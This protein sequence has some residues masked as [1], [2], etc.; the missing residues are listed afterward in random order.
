[1]KSKRIAPVALFLTSLGLGVGFWPAGCARNATAVGPKLEPVSASAPGALAPSKSYD[2]LPHPAFA[3]AAEGTPGDVT[4]ADIAER[5]TPS[6][7]NISSQRTVKGPE[8]MQGDPTFNQFFGFGVPRERRERGLG[9]GVIVSSDGIVLT[10]NHVIEQSDEIT[11]TTNDGRD[12]QA[13]LVG[14][15]E[16]S[17]VA[18]IRLKG[19]I[20]G[21]KPLAYG[22][23]GALRLGD[24][25]LAIGNP[26]GLGQTVTMG[27]VSAKGRSDT[28]IV[29]YAD[30]IQ[31]DAA[32][33]PGNSGGALVNMAGELVGINT[34]IL[35]RSGG[36]QGIGF[37]IPSNMAKPISESLLQYGKVTRGWLGIAIQDVDPPVATAMGLPNADGVLATDVEPNSPAAKAGIVR[38]DVILRF[39]GEKVDAASRLRNLVASA[40]ANKVVHVDVLRNGQPKTIDV[41]LGTLQGKDDGKG[42]VG[43]PHDERGAQQPLVGVSVEPLSPELRQRLNVPERIQQGIVVTRVAPGSEAEEGGLRPGDVIIEVNRQPVTG[44]DTLSKAFKKDDKKGVLLLVFNGGGT[45]Y[46]VVKP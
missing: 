18:V 11:V 36:Y 17:D 42:K 5:V 45:R 9:S 10:N 37:A 32:I 24:V 8:G 25:V 4:I 16:K 38:G 2:F 44:S 35:S 46:V 20:K 28:G 3:H 34:A 30:F 7:V 26:F 39:D 43:A 23:S 22:D 1:M 6:V 31:T 29:D 19:D 33:N 14:T 15:D 12:F 40:G 21:L 41:T 27:I 13:E